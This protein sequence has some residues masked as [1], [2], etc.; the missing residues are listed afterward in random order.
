M[1]EATVFAAFLVL[2]VVFHRCGRLHDV[3]IVRK[4][5]ENHFVVWLFHPAMLHTAQDYMVHF[6]V[7]SGHVLG[8]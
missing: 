1:Q 6:V 5:A 2:Q 3:W 7:Y 4:I 8:H